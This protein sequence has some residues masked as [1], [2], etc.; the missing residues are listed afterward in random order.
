MSRPARPLPSTTRR[1]HPY[2]QIYMSTFGPS[3]CWRKPRQLCSTALKLSQLKAQHLSSTCGTACRQQPHSQ[4]R[5][6]LCVECFRPAGMTTVPAPNP[7]CGQDPC[8][9]FIWLGL[10]SS[11]LTTLAGLLVLI[12]A[13]RHHYPG[14]PSS[15]QRLARLSPGL[16]TLVTGPIGPWQFWRSLLPRKVFRATCSLRADQVYHLAHAQSSSIPELRTGGGQ[17]HLEHVSLALQPA[18]PNY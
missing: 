1:R 7:V 14:R 8:Y 13:Q 4:A 9:T 2:H 12:A 15:L 10:M 17:Q 16:Q 5:S 11:G 18:S 6:S 3:T